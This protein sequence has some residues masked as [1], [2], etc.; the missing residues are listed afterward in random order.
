MLY[1]IQSSAKEQLN[2]PRF[3]VFL[4]YRSGVWYTPGGGK[5]GKIDYT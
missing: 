5:Y 3:F 4:A 1:A 2:D